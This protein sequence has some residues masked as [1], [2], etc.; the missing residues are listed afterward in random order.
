MEQLVRESRQLF[1]VCGWKE[2]RVDGSW[3]GERGSQQGS[4]AE[5]NLEP[6]PS[7]KRPVSPWF[8]K[9]G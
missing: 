8:G 7:P 5:W 1:C 2:A 6:N 9:V 4:H 3:V